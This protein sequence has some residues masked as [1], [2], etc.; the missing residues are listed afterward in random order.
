MLWF[1]KLHMGPELPDTVQPERGFKEKAR[2][3]SPPSALWETL[4]E[5]WWLLIREVA[6]LAQEEGLN[7]HQ[8]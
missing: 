5:R 7:T 1:G 3:T 6:Y 4:E 8:H 2:A